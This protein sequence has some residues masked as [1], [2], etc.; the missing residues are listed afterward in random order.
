MERVRTKVEYYREIHN[1]VAV[2]NKLC[3]KTNVFFPGVDQFLDNLLSLKLS[4][5]GK[6]Q[7]FCLLMRYVSKANSNQNP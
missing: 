6:F 5:G 4:Y 1:R 7:K 3:D 2:K